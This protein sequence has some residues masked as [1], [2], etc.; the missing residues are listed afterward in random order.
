MRKFCNND[1]FL[2]VIVYGMQ[3]QI[4]IIENLRILCESNIQLR[5]KF[6]VRDIQ[7]L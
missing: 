1:K 7:F 4:N 2:M 6:L 3:K 5:L